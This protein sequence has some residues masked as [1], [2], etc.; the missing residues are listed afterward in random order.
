MSQAADLFTILR[1]YANQAKTPTLRVDAFVA[2]LEKYAK[3]YETERPDL[4]PWAVDTADKVQAG[5]RAIAETGRCTLNGGDRNLTVTISQYF[6]DLLQQVYR[7]L[8]E[9]PEILFPDEA[10]IRVSIPDDQLRAIKLDEDFADYLAA[11]Q[12]A[13][14]PIIKL[15]FADGLGSILL[16][17]GMIPKKILELAFIKARHYLRTHN[18]KEYV[19]HKLAP[20][21]QG[22]E[23]LLKEAV[24]QLM[25]RPFD[26]IAEMERA[27]DFS[28]P[29]WAYFASLVK[30][31]IRKKNDQLP[32]D[33]AI[34]QAVLLIE[35]FN[36]YYK[37]K[38]QKERDTDT[39]LRNLDLLLDKAPFHYSL[40]DIT[41]FTDTKGVPLLGQYS[42]E[43]LEEFIK[44]KTTK[45]ESLNKLPELLI[46]H[47]L[48]GERWYVKKGNMLPLCAKLI[49]EARPRIKSSITQRWFRLMSDFQSV[50]EME[51]DDA[52]DLELTDMTEQTAPVLLALLQE[53]TLYL[54][55]EETSGSE[56]GIPE[57][58]RLFY[59]GTLA[60]MSELFLLY[61]KDLLTD[62]RML[63]PFWYTIPF[64]SA[65]IAFFHRRSQPKPAATR[66]APPPRNEQPIHA[67][68][69]EP[70]T[71]KVDRK[72]ELKNAARTI[73]KRLVPE[74]STLE[75]YLSQLEGKWN[76]IIN[77]QAKKN[78]TED[79][80]SLIRD[81]LRKTA[82]TLKA[83]TFTPERIQEL[84]RTL[85]ESPSLTKIPSRDA[86]RIYIQLYMV[87]LV[88]KS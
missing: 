87:K 7:T 22:K 33:I 68:D 6:V 16:L 30:G 53:K 21:F 63:L 88:L 58:S 84:A 80:N 64:F 82:R 62:V 2:F 79:V 61:R 46:I 5:L 86:L 66:R 59:R 51:S 42:V 56:T 32:E 57:A 17:S 45:T 49:G 50:P 55:H 19:L 71:H 9:T 12:G 67:F 34:M 27:G 81:Y 75:S 1:F 73:E 39:A 83:A 85:S 69:D 23:S 47:G 44:T 60:P 15:V 78:L 70:K 26:S 72:T 76:R 8:E 29:F 48:K 25:T 74:G 41:Q 77:P 35:F 11:P 28:F 20:A 3:R 52:F 65:I 31:D 13:P 40:D 38:A 4:A 37:G 24:N 36:N 14:L 10:G 18:N 54:V 43:A